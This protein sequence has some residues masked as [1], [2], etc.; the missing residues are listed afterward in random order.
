M[1]VR[2]F[3]TLKWALIIR[4]PI[5]YPL[6]SETTKYDFLDKRSGFKVLSRLCRTFWSVLGL[7][8]LD[9]RGSE[10]FRPP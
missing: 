9:P 5:R 3:V 1:G 2:K 6:I 7:S 8:W 4:T 10:S